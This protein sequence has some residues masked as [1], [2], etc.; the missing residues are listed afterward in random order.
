M[1]NGGSDVCLVGSGPQK[2]HT[3]SATLFPLS[4]LPAGN[5][6]IKRE[7]QVLRDGETTSWKETGLRIT[8]CMEGC[9][10]WSIMWA[11]KKLPLC[12]AAEIW[13]FKF[14]RASPNW[15]RAED[16]LSKRIFFFLTLQTKSHRDL[17]KL[18]DGLIE[19]MGCYFLQSD[20]RGTWVVPTASTFRATLQVGAQQNLCT[21][22]QG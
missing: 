10:Y 8:T 13:G 18:Q 19:V 2:P 20:F 12:E 3:G 22:L 21:E 7:L 11:R 16:L 15:W 4:H 1:K 14:Q 6:N 17:F 5:R 9:L